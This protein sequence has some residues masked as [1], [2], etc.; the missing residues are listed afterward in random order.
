MYEIVLSI[1]SWIRWL[2]LIIGMLVIFRSIYGWIK[3]AEYTHGDNILSASL[4]GLFYT[5]LIVGLL[6]Y[7][8]LSPLTETALS[9]FGKAMRDPI[10]RFWSLE[11]ILVM[12]GAVTLAQIGRTR[13]NK[14][15][16]HIIKFR[17]QSV[18]FILA[19]ILVLSRIPWYDP[20]RLFRG[21]S[22]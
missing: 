1:H 4:V 12:I 11:H 21:I 17:T 14:T 20:V 13:S 22:Q 18:Y 5:Q 8:V 10:L 7:F 2:L 15:V 9:D 6:L 3:Q 16:N 19:L